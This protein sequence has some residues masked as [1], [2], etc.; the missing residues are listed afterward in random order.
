MAQVKPQA[1]STTLDN[2]P[3]DLWLL[4]TFRNATVFRLAFFPRVL[5]GVQCY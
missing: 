3:E 2:K 5:I 1:C 4:A